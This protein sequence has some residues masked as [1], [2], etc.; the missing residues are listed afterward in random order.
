MS[1]AQEHS[2]ACFI[3]TYFAAIVFFL[4]EWGKQKKADG[5]S[6]SLESVSLCPYILKT[7]L[8]FKR[9][10][11]TIREIDIHDAYKTR[12]RRSTELGDTKQSS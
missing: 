5:T 7:R 1:Y 12:A 9:K 8:I 6:L 2:T 10:C 3:G 4:R 11:D